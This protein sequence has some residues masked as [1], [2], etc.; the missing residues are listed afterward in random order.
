[1]ALFILTSE[2][3]SPMSLGPSNDYFSSVE[4]AVAFARVEF[5][6][7]EEQVAE[8][9][10]EQTVRIDDS[11]VYPDR[12]WLTKG[13]EVDPEPAPPSGESS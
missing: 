10:D 2:N 8:L 4:K 11:R 5:L 1:M 6:L 13:A 7:T 3:D 9:L 12:V